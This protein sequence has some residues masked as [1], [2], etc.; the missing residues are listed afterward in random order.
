MT[1]T[2]TI[3]H[4]QFAPSPAP[5][6]A[7]SLRAPRCGLFTTAR[8]AASDNRFMSFLGWFIRLVFFALVLW[9]ALKNT[10][11]VPLRFT[12][13]L[14]YDGVPLI[15]I[16]LGCFVLGVIAGAAA[17]APR[18]FR[19]RRQAQAVQRDATKAAAAALA[20][21]ERHG[22]ELASAARNAGAA[23]QLDADTRFP[24]P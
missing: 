22:D 2:A 4:L 12:E 3:D 10:T 13:T 9:F 8:A 24:R 7:F 15:V 16:I 18:L 14:R 11:P 5:C 21:A 17:L 1:T 23:G 20:A 6:G 19:L